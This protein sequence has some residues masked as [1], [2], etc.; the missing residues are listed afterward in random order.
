MQIHQLSLTY[1]EIEDRILLRVN[2]TDE[3][4]A[5]FWFTRRM[6]F[7]ILPTLPQV[8]AEQMALTAPMNTPVHSEL[9]K[10]L[11]GEL[12][13]QELLQRSDFSTPY[14]SA[15]HSLTEGRPLLVTE[16]HL[17]TQKNGHTLCV[18]SERPADPQLKRSFQLHLTP[19]LLRGLL[20]LLEEVLPKSG[21]QA[22][23]KAHKPDGSAALQSLPKGLL[24]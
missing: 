12:M 13:G 11:F 10:G 3:S 6:T 16:I 20:H 24:N 19:Q 5:L 21:W 14:K 7:H 4:E 1:D 22:P 2:T 18:L 17:E 9:V 15:I 8:L 23:I